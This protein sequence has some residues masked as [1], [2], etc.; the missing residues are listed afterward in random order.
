M[1]FGI[2]YWLQNIR[3]YHHPWQPACG[4]HRS[5]VCKIGLAQDDCILFVF[6]PDQTRRYPREIVDLNQPQMLSWWAGWNWAIDVHIRGACFPTIGN[7]SKRDKIHCCHDCKCKAS[8]NKQSMYLCHGYIPIVSLKCIFTVF[9]TCCHTHY[10]VLGKG[11]WRKLCQA[12]LLNY[13]TICSTLINRLGY[14]PHAGDR[15]RVLFLSIATAFDGGCFFLFEPKFLS[16]HRA[17]LLS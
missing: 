6:Q 10:W 9:A 8:L 7:I 15:E 4:R 14:C 5:A 11:F 1:P 17:I 12:L 16:T 13:L 2:G 3:N